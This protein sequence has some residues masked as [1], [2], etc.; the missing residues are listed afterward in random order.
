V[1]LTYPII[2]G[3]SGQRRTKRLGI[4]R[5]CKRS[6]SYGQFTRERHVFPC[7]N[8]ALFWVGPLV[9]SVSHY[10]SDFRPLRSGL[11]GEAPLRGCLKNS[12]SGTPSVA[13]SRSNT[14]T[15]GFS[16]RRSRPPTY[17]RSTSAS[18]ARRSCDRPRL[19]LSRLKFQATS[20]RPFMPQG[21]HPV[22][23]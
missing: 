19:T 12:A 2:G 1:Q 5:H 11:G 15:V 18:Y 14:S 23:Y 21:G 6:P 22:G 16:T 4:L 17:E 20:A 8:A 10:R 9:G 3:H 7:F 13:A